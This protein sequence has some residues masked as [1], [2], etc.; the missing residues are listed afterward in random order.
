M[1]A[2]FGLLLLIIL[3]PVKTNTHM[4][5]LALVFFGGLTGS[6]LY[7]GGKFGLK[8]IALGDVL[9]LIIFGPLSI[10]FSYMAQTGTMDLITLRYAIPLAMNTEAILHSNNTRDIEADKR[11][12]L[13]TI[14]IL[15]GPTCSHILFALLL[16]VP[17]IIFILLSL[18][19]SAWFM[20]PII[21]LARAFRIERDFR[22]QLL[23]N[24]PK[25]TAK[26]NIYLG[27]FYITSL[28][29]VPSQKLP[30]LNIN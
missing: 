18:H 23:D 25:A 8:Y 6:F 20:L 10:L 22:A 5:H 28:I 7:T 11:A 14:P 4:A 26:L 24:V 1:V 15:I 30:W 29:L 12:G 27:L 2:C 13:V 21:T 16:F 19:F 17:Y 3:S 9:I